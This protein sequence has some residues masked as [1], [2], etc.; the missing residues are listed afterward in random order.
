ML[1]VLK[2]IFVFAQ[3]PNIQWQK[4]LGGSNAD[5]ARTI[6]ITNGGGF[7]VL[8][9][10][11]SN[12]FDV[13]GNRGQQDY[14]IVKIDSLGSIQWQKSL[15]GSMNDNGQAIQQ[16]T[17]GGYILSGS[18]NS[19][20]GDV[21][22]NHGLRDY[23][24]VKIDS[25]GN[26][27]WQKS[28]GGSNE[29]IAGNIEITN[30]GG[31]IVAGYSFSNDGDVSGNHGGA[32]FWIVK[33]D[34][35]GNIQWQKSLGGTDA[36]IGYYSQLTNDEGYVVVGYSYSNDGD[37][38]SN[39]G[40]ADYWIVKLDSLGNILWQKSFGGTDEEYCYSI[41]QTRDSGFVM[42]GFS[43]SNDGDV[44]G[45]HGGEDYWVVKLDSLANIQWQKSLGGTGTDNGLSVLQ[46]TNKDYIIAGYSNSNDGDVTG[47]HGGNDYWI[48]NIDSLGDIQWQKSFGG[49]G[50]DFVNS[51]SEDMVGA[52]IVGGTSNSNDG[53][54]AGNHGGQDYWIVKLGSGN[55]NQIITGTVTNFLLQTC[56]DSLIATIPFTANGT[57]NNGNIFTAELSDETGSF[58]NPVVIGTLNGTISD[59]IYATITPDSLKNGAGYRIRV[60][61]SNPAVVGNNNGTD[62]AITICDDGN[63]CTDDYCFN[64]VCTWI[65][66][67]CNDNNSCTNDT[68]INGQCVYTPVGSGVD[69][70]FTFITSNYCDTLDVDFINNS[71][72]G[73]NYLW[74]FGD[75]RSSILQNPNIIYNSFDTF[76]VSLIVTDTACGISDTAYANIVFEPTTTN[77]IA[78]FSY[79]ATQDCQTMSV[80]FTNTSTGGIGYL[81]DFGNGLTSN[82]I[83]PV[84]IYQDTG[85]YTITL[86][87]LDSGFCA[88][89]DTFQTQVLFE[90]RC[91]IFG[92]VFKDV[93][94][95]CI[96]EAGEN[97]FENAII[98]VA[99][100][101]AGHD[102]YF[103]STDSNGNYAV[104]IND[105]GNY[106]VELASV[107]TYWQASC[108]LNP[109]FYAVNVNGQNAVNVN[110]G[111]Y[112]DTAC[113]KL[114]VDISSGLIRRNQRTTFAVDYCNNGSGVANNVVVEVDFP[115]DKIGSNYFFQIVNSSIPGTLL[116]G[117]VYSY[118]IGTLNAGDCGRILIS[119]FFPVIT[120]ERTYCTKASIFPKINCQPVD[121]IWDFSD[122]KVEGD[123]SGDTTVSI[124]VENLGLDMLGR[125]EYRVYE[126]ELLIDRDSF[127]IAAGDSIVKQYNKRA[128]K[129]IH[130][131]ADQ[132][133]GHP[134]NSF[135]NDHVEGCDSI[136]TSSGGFVNHFILDDV[137]DD[138]ETDCKGVSI[139]WDPN[140]KQVIPIGISENHYIDESTLLEYTIR[141]QNT[142]N[143]T[144]F[145]VQI[146]DTLDDA[147]LDI[148]SIRSGVSSHENN[149]RV[150]GAG[151]VEWTFDNILLPDSNV[152]EE[153]SHGFVKF[154][155]NLKEGISKGSIIEN[156]AA[157][158][159][160]FNA[161]V[162]TNTVFN[163]IYDTILIASTSIEKGEGI[164]NI[165][166]F[167]NPFAENTIIAFDLNNS[168]YVNLKVM[169]LMGKVVMDMPKQ[170]YNSG[171]HEIIFSPANN[172]SG[173]FIIDLNMNGNRVVKRVVRMN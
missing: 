44:T 76:S 154:K 26:I 118:N 156:N 2:C 81:W 64:G 33:L 133:P 30:D 84:F 8:G 83:E 57:Y 160:D 28:I 137:A 9:L 149:F 136:Y 50:N 141:F 61:S 85:L 43:R 119:V 99:P 171:R 140:D 131:E 78:S 29:D 21:T 101:I 123:C 153:E 22:G 127:Q 15:G 69:A 82:D 1:F 95:N 111:N 32:D 151:I 143:D 126:D 109:A 20:D 51:I 72:G 152:N 167:P 27:Q 92:N 162:I 89:N 112:I 98:K 100:G 47:N 25:I 52:N 75:G 71:S 124:V 14:W 128:N 161:P 155:I 158:Y 142:G 49:T 40:G 31:Y 53:D 113:S 10:S 55:Q 102:A 86:V 108:P 45:N 173:I 107:L 134:N 120:L 16:T 90:N 59:T 130:I 56:G 62:L 60:N 110:F 168:A 35:L 103:A 91:K 11:G 68:C 163:T 157:I 148:S 129:E 4:S 121:S 87:T 37:V 146:L 66:R 18:S 19:N 93:N 5:Q 106:T 79:T 13:T 97:G 70:N 122:I 63:A 166:V 34:G 46:T 12:D 164:S 54:V 132:R 3:A 96:K 116:N 74:D 144:A 39:H 48:V 135:P 159:F 80:N 73:T 23:W 138:V 88:K 36:D 114:E 150:F 115:D 139:S 24:V 165:V 77:P 172:L 117:R 104:L 125:S 94:Q 17:D 169:D 58:L 145:W 105:T 65:W 41:Q 67:Q 42:V 7:I 38:S 147:L 6:A 170:F